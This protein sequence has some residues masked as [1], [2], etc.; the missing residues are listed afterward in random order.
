MLTAFVASPRPP[1][2]RRPDH[3]TAVQ[4]TL[5]ESGVPPA[6]FLKLAKDRGKWRKLAR[7]FAP[8]L[9]PKEYKHAAIWGGD[10][11]AGDVARSC[12]GAG[13]RRV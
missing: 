4:Q 1:R 9:K 3:A 7:S 8:K 11:L 5:R 12:G 2:V 13:A 10:R 6:T